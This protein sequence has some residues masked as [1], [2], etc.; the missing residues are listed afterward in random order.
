MSAVATLR[1]PTTA[2]STPETDS[3]AVEATRLRA[4][5]LLDAVKAQAQKELLSLLETVKLD[6]TLA[7]ASVP[8]ATP[9]VVTARLTSHCALSLRDVEIRLSNARSQAGLV[10]PEGSVEVPFTFTAK[11]QRKHSLLLEWSAKRIDGAALKGQ[12]ELIIEAV[13]SRNV[14]MEGS[15]TIWKDA[16]QKHPKA[17]RAAVASCERSQAGLRHH[18]GQ[19]V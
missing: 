5:K 1:L 12:I 19:G 7:P 14:A 17:H 8:V 15:G 2:Q 3:L 16:R 4:T 11:H 6:V 18:K 13:S 10:F 9:T